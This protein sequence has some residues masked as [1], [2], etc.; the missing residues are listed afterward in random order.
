M[1]Y[2]Y[3]LDN[4]IDSKKN[5]M[6][7]E[8]TVQEMV[9]VLNEIYKEYSAE[10]VFAFYDSSAPGR[11]E[12]EILFQIES[13]GKKEFFPLFSLNIPLSISLKPI[14][15]SQRK[16][17]GYF[18]LGGVSRDL[19]NTARDEYGIDTSIRVMNSG[20]PTTV[21]EKI[22]ELFK[23]AEPNIDQWKSFVA[24]HDIFMF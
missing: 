13:T 18:A 8:N 6:D 15:L 20:V 16:F 11:M 21:E 12:A 10:V 4:I 3:K 5:R 2:K 1:K 9:R 22:K 19:F 7:I 17:S 23:M 24:M 14:S